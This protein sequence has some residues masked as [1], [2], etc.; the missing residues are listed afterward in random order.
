ML[1]L[2]FVL[3]I[4]AFS[5]ALLICILMKGKMSQ[6]RGLAAFSTWLTFFL[7]YVCRERAAL[8]SYY[9]YLSIQTAISALILISVM[10]LG[11]LV[12]AERIL[13][14]LDHGRY[15][16]PRMRIVLV[17]V[18]STMCIIVGFFQLPLL[19]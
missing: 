8:N 13:A 9:D 7:L 5:A 14:K 17:A 12:W 3:A 19:S 2:T 11:C 18:V 1:L 16:D 6:P 10:S 4:L 15:R